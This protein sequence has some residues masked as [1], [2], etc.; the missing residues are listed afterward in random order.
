MVFKVHSR[1]NLNCTYCYMYNRGDTSYLGQPKRVSWDVVR[2]IPA[3][4]RSYLASQGTNIYSISFHGGEPLLVG[5]DFFDRMAGYLRS[6]LS[7]I[8]L[9][10]SV[11]TNGT[12]VDSEWAHLFNRHRVSVSVSLDGPPPVNG[13]FRVYHDGRD[14][15]ADAIAAVRL[16]QREADY[17][18]GVLCVSDPA[19]DGGAVVRFFTDELKLDWFDLLWPDYSHDNLPPNFA[20]FSSGMLDFMVS[21]FEEWYPRSRS[22]VACR[23]FDSIIARMVG[24]PSRVDTIGIDGLTTVVVET[25]GT[26]E[27]HD[28]LRVCPEFDRH[29][30]IRV[31]EGAI[32]R[33]QSSLAYTRAQNLEGQHSEECLVCPVF[34]ICRGGHTTHR[35]SRA[36]GFQNRS[37]YCET[38]YALITHIQKRLGAVLLAA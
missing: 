2:D 28:V 37:V 20:S 22:G 35:Y 23:F 24:L 5:K 30:G 7:D 12:L 29:T 18:G 11:Q 1:C 3:T 25:D 10:L 16:L 19:A 4:V 36:N 9:R 27:P 38:L 13:K 17:F 14:S 31:G 26:L 15:T 32:Q 33:F 34:S 8:D 6:E 21:A